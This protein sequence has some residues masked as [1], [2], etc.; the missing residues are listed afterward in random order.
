MILLTVSTLACLLAI[1]PVGLFITNRPAF[2]RASRTHA[3][4]ERMPRVSILIPARDEED[5]IAACVTAALETRHAEV[6]IIVLDDGSRDQTAAIIQSIARHD[7]RV[8]LESAPALPPGWCGKQHACFILSR[9]ARHD[10]LLFI[11]ADVR[12]HPMAVASAARILE[13]TNADLLSGFPSQET[14]SFL[15]KLLIPLIH[16]LLLSYLPI[17]RMRSSP[18]T[19]Y[20]AGCGQLFLAR[21]AAYE[22]IGG[23]SAIRQSM[24]D[25]LTLPRAFRK[26]GL[27]T[28]L[29]DASG[30]ATC[31]MYHG[32][33]ATWRGLAKNATEAMA[34]P[35]AI[36]PWT[37]LLI[38]G[39]VLPLALLAWLLV[40]TGPDNP[41]T[42]DL[43]ISLCATATLLS[44]LSRAMM[45]SRFAHSP[46]GVLLHPLAI[47]LLVTI[48]WDALFR[49]LLGRPA[50]WRGRD[51]PAYPTTLSPHASRS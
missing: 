19:A 14:G 9:L 40:T 29:F 47:L 42:R 18:N 20:A 39:Q 37:L 12:L 48:Q 8:R 7:P 31:R 15:E 6:E 16:F 50:R 23:H 3:R 1:V 24:H 46:L 17:R 5:V 2:R 27:R 36:V 13:E 44:Y 32:N 34:S 45:A 4:P 33:S 28:D 41:A 38:G 30:L 21:R 11:D 51:Y 22:Q 25:G 35:L 49:K 43:A 26:A 10:L